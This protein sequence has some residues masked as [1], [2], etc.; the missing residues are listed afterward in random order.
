M[1]AGGAATAGAAGGI[2]SCKQ[3]VPVLCFALQ[4]VDICTE[5]KK[6]ETPFESNLQ[7]HVHGKSMYCQS[8][9]IIVYDMAVSRF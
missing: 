6:C 3:W 2:C 8:S 1:P 9:E 4:L 5:L 7:G